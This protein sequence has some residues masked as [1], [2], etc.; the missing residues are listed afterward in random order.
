MLLIAAVVVAVATLVRRWR[1][2]DL[3]IV[4]SVLTG[5]VIIGLV[6]L[7]IVA[8][9][10]AVAAAIGMTFLLRHVWSAPAGARA[11]G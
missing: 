2:A 4:A 11:S 1:R 5:V 6:G 9:L 7:T 10:L 3:I 8:L